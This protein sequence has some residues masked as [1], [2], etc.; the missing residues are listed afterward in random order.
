MLGCLKFDN[1]DIRR[2]ED[3]MKLV[4]NTLEGEKCFVE[5]A[6]E[7]TLFSMIGNARDEGYFACLR[8]MFLV[9]LTWRQNVGEP[10]YS[11]ILQES[12]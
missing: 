2:D 5:R 6:V 3:I 10:R 7:G 9:I 1:P 11:N 12:Q 8:K 4:Q